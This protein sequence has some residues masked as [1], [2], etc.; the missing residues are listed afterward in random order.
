MGK[1]ADM[2]REAHQTGRESKVGFIYLNISIFRK[3][4]KT[5]IGRLK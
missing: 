3:F 2:L 1:L 5:G 4:I